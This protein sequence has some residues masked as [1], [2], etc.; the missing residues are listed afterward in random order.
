MSEPAEQRHATGVVNEAAEAEKLKFLGMISHELKTPLN[1]IIGFSNLIEVEALGPLGD[2]GYKEF[3]K[4]IQTSGQAL[5]YLVNELI[6]VSHTEAGAVTFA[7]SHVDLV[8][9]AA[10]SVAKLSAEA[11]AKGIVL[12]NLI[13]D[14]APAIWADQRV[15]AQTLGAVLHNAIKF[16]EAKGLVS[17]EYALEDNG[18][19]RLLVSDT[20]CGIHS[21]KLAEI[22]GAFNQADQNINRNYEGA[23]LGL[24][25][26]Q[27]LVAQH[28]GRIEI[29][30]SPGDGARV[31]IIL[32]N[33]RLL[34]AMD[35]DDLT[36][37]ADDDDDDGAAATTIL[38]LSRGGQQYQAFAGA[39][40][41]VIG[42]VSS[43]SPVADI[44][45]VIDDRRVSRP[46][47]RLVW[48]DGHFHLVDES[49]RGTFIVGADGAIEHV[50]MNV[51]QPLAGAGNFTLGDAPDSEDPVRVQYD[52]SVLDAA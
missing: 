40:E 11:S 8:S 39:K 46:H 13:E 4:E 43:T 9:L 22:F 14:G 10:S 2:N 26:A 31:A 32:P 49:K 16:K 38:S 48:I 3:A 50:T 34:S 21:D 52:V 36:V 33:D 24:Y 42:R 15:L 5:L 19:L 12:Q 30:T 41:F 20:G 47:A 27:T 29:D 44:D 23:G 1:A 35:E 18:D 25:L 17:L 51:S 7:E 37:M 6:A 28:S 45:L